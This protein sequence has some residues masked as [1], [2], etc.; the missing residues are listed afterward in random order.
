LASQAEGLGSSDLPGTYGNVGMIVQDLEHIFPGS[1]PDAAEIHAQAWQADE[2]T[3]GSYAFYRPG[4][5]FG[6]RAILQEPHMRVYF[7]GEHLA[8]EQGF[9]E[10]AVVTGK[11]AAENVQKAAASKLL[12]ESAHPAIAP[13]LYGRRNILTGAPRE[14]ERH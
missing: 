14:N 5:W 10:G 9:M 8:D 7:A 4:Q 12:H 2:Y 1:K 6:I 3:Q 11:D 13:Y